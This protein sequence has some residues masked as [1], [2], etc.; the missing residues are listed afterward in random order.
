MTGAG[1]AADGGAGDSCRGSDLLQPSAR[2]NARGNSFVFRATSQRKRLK[3]TRT[4]EGRMVKAN[5]SPTSGGPASSNV[6]FWHSIA[7]TI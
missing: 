1:A 4:A 3:R 5:C 7:I 2:K 6:K